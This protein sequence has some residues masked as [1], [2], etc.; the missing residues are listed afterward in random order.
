[1]LNFITF[2]IIGALVASN[3]LGLWFENLSASFNLESGFFSDLLSCVW[4]LGT[5]VSLFLGIVFAV[6][7]AVP[8][9]YLYVLS[10][11]FSWPLIANKIFRIG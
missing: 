6:T 10:S 1:M 8:L 7:C 3:V 11:A 5:W 2:Y 9:P 4:C